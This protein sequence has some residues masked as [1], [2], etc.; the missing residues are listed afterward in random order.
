LNLDNLSQK[1]NL[2]SLSPGAQRGKR[3]K[4]ENLKKE[5]VHG[6]RKGGRKLPDCGAEDAEL[7]QF[8]TAKE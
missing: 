8:H 1:D 6:H 3:D 5:G 4:A 7:H 2:L